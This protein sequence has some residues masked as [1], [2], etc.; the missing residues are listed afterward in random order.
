M[1]SAAVEV[2]GPDAERLA[3]ELRAAVLNAAD[4]GELVAPVGW[5]EVDRRGWEIALRQR[6]EPGSSRPGQ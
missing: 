1:A 5:S 6:T 2:S 3:A 4:P